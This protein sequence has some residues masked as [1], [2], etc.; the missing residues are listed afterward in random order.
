MSDA[1]HI[2]P[3][4]RVRGLAVLQG[5]KSISHRALIFASLADGISRIENLAT[6]DDVNATI[7]VL[8]TLGIEITLAPDGENASIEGRGGIFDQPSMP[9]DCGNSA[10]TMSL[11]AGVLASQPFESILTGDES[12]SARPMNYIAEPLRKFGAV[13]ET[14]ENGRPPLKI[15]GGKLTGVLYKPKIA[16]A[17]IKSTVL[18]AGLFATGSTIFHESLQTRD[19]TERLISHLCEKGVIDID[20]VEKTITVRKMQ[21]PIEPFDIVIPG[22]PSSAAYPIALATLLPE[23]SLTVPF[24]GLNAGR[25][26]FFRQLQAMGAH[27]VMSRDPHSGKATGGEPVGEITV[28]SARLKNVPIDPA[29]IPAIIDEI[30]LL[31]VVSCHSD[32]NWEISGAA[33]LREKETDRI[34]TTVQMLEFMGAKVEETEDGLKGGGG[35]NFKGGDI[36]CIFDHRIAMSAAIAGWCSV[37]PTAINCPECIRI[38]FP[39]FFDLMQNLVEYQ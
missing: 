26:G 35:Q 18:L 17:Q 36:P 29:R 21:S 28:H 3:A 16:S 4:V 5:D 6:S 20:R 33:R 19:H 7:R 12:L 32:R 34:K 24:V 25:I 39:K 8:R 27:L 13:V 15:T 22:D 38:S 11:M 23:S 31:A 37:S 1:I 9:L 30:P 10:T 2:K 14:S